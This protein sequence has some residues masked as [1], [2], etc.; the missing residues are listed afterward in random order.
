MLGQQEQD[1]LNPRYRSPLSWTIGEPNLPGSANYGQEFSPSPDQS[2]QEPWWKPGLDTEAFS[3]SDALSS[4]GSAGQGESAQPEPNKRPKTPS[5]ENAKLLSGVRG[6]APDSEESSP[7]EAPSPIPAP[8]PPGTSGAPGPD[9]GDLQTQQN[10]MIQAPPT[11][12]KVP[13][14]GQSGEEDPIQIGLQGAAKRLIQRAEQPLPEKKNAKGPLGWLQRL[15]SAYLATT[16]LA[17]MAD[18]IIH[19]K[20]SKQM[21]DLREADQRDRQELKDLESVSS[22][23]DLGEQRKA[24]AQQYRDTEATKRMG[25]ESK[26]DISVRAAKQKQ[27]AELLRHEDATLKGRDAMEL[28]EGEQPPPGWDLINS[29]ARPG[30]RFAAAPRFVR[31][32]EEMLPYFAGRKAGDAVPYEE[33]KQ[34]Q[35]TAQQVLVN[36]NKPDLRQ[37]QPEQQFIDEFV[38]THPGASIAQAQKA[39]ELNKQLPAQPQAPPHALMF[40]PDGVAFE[41]KPGMTIPKGSQ[42]AQGVN[43]VNTGTSTTRTMREM[44]GTVVEQVPDLLNQVENLKAKIGPAKGRWNE[45]WT[46][47]VGLNDP[48][49]AGLDQDLDMFASAIVRTHFG[50]RGSENYREALRKNFRMAQSPD[51]LKARIQHADKWL[52]SY[53]KM[54]TPGTKAPTTPGT[55]QAPGVP[56]AVVKWGRDAK[57]NPIRIP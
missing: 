39:Y 15:G 14:V 53:S 8:G 23:L 34:A 51:D 48:E 32:P 6:P 40:G 49:F 37:V 17:P 54:G 18:Q 52:E 31:L 9:I 4:S 38:K 42:T 28:Q 33:F 13:S 27:E 55:P 16:A 10:R 22:T 2:W 3:P 57:G 21:S 46:N 44:A 24:H 30:V 25:I 36:Q 35:H 26:E 43:T 12:A 56:P 7:E 50:G 47:K 5:V 45:L 11:G 1:P 41:A 20:Y 19:P 29:V